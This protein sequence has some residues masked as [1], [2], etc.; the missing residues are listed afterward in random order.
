MIGFTEKVGQN[1][2]TKCGNWQEPANSPEKGPSTIVSVAAQNDL[3]SKLRSQLRRNRRTRSKRD[4][5][6]AKATKKKADK[7][8]RMAEDDEGENDEEADSKRVMRRPASSYSS[9]EA[10][11]KPRKSIAK[12]KAKATAKTKRT[13]DDDENDYDN[14]D[15]IDE[16]APLPKAKAKAKCKAKAKAKGKAKSAPR[17]SDEGMLQP[18]YNYT[19]YS[20]CGN[21]VLGC[22]TC[23]WSVLGCALMCLRKNFRGKRW[24]A[25]ACPED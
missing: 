8:R 12:A 13:R 4:I 9:M 17:K 18:D 10:S 25:T 20:A 14:D 5:L 24:N 22:P 3:R 15:D 19:G 7:K 6:K 23:R 2:Y 21:Y 11:S 16:A 1:Y